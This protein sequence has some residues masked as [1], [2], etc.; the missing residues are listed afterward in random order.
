[1]NETMDQCCC[2]DG[3]ADIAMMK[4]FM[5]HCGKSEFSDDDLHMMKEFGGCEGKPDI[6]K[7]TQMMELF[8]CHLPEST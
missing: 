8:G 6:A 1:M 4:Q 5:E 7:M 3:K 2:K